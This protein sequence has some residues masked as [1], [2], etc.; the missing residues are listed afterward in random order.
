MRMLR[1]R[2]ELADVID[3]YA[4]SFDRRDWDTWMTCWAPT[5][6]VDFSVMG[7]DD[8]LPEGDLPDGRTALDRKILT[9]LVS[10]G[11]EG[12]P[13]SQHLK[14]PLSFAID[15]DVAQVVS[16]M[17]AKHMMPSAA[18]GGPLQTMVGYCDDELTRGAEGWQSR[19]STRSST[20][21]R[22]TPSR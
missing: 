18:T 13:A 9:E 7:L 6:A 15:G 4:Y 21:T 19:R 5:V 1:H 17:Q 10:Q 16:L 3:R 22:G 12:V 20:G 11:F 14:I 8:V 2:A